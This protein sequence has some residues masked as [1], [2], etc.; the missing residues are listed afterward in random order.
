MAI[1][2]LI[3]HGNIAVTPGVLYGRTPGI[4]LNEEGR[5]QAHSMADRF[6]AIPV[7]A[8]YCSPLERA[9]ETAQP[10][11]DVLK[12]P[13]QINE[14]FLEVEYGDWTGRSFTELERDPQWRVYNTSRTSACIPRGENI[15]QL[16]ARFVKAM[17]E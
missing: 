11:A 9:V 1:F 13:M 2:Y 15:L 5:A 8:L 12:L 4:H 6:R 3:R 14:G 10:L 7:T 17:E 16:Q